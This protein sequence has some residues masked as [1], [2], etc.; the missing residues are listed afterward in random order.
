M[1]NFFNDD[2]SCLCTSNKE[3]INAK[4]DAERFMSFQEQSALS[5]LQSLQDEGLILV[6]SPKKPDFNNRSKFYPIHYRPP[7]LD[8]FQELVERDLKSFSNQVLKGLSDNNNII[9][10]P[11]DKGGGGGHC[12]SKCGY[13]TKMLC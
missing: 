10:W 7:I 6:Q 9:V 4:G 8:S 5:A 2:I 1:N 3:S 11:A 13:Y 12:N